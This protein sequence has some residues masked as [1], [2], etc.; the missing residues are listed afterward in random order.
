[1]EDRYKYRVF[2]K[3]TK[4]FEYSFVGAINTQPFSDITRYE[5]PQMCTGLIDKN[6]KLIY[7]GDILKNVVNEYINN[8]KWVSK[9]YKGI[10]SFDDGAYK[11]NNTCLKNSMSDCEYYYDAFDCEIIGNIWQ[12]QT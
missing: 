3:H 12:N 8:G 2:N 4:E 1:M 11:F 5:K 7:E 10:V 6:S 9:E